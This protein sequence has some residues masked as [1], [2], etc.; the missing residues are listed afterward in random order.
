[1]ELIGFHVSYSTVR[2]F[3]QA[4]QSFTT[5]MKEEIGRYAA[6]CGI[7]AAQ[8]HYSAKLNKTISAALVRKFRRMYHRMMLVSQSPSHRLGVKYLFKNLYS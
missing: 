5:Q 1:M 7:E 4:F 2:N 8:K 6:E 3:V